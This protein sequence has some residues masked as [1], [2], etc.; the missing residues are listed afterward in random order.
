MNVYC[1]Q[2]LYHSEPPENPKETKSVIKNSNKK[3][4]ITW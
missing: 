1:W 3:K 2:I 4:S